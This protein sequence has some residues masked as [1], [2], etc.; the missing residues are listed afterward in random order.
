MTVGLEPIVDSED[1]AVSLDRLRRAFETVYPYF[2][3]WI[4]GV[5][6]DLDSGERLLYAVLEH[7]RRVGYFLVHPL[8]RRVLKANALLILDP[9]RR[10]GIATA[11]YRCLLSDAAERYDFVFTQAKRDHDVAL[12]LLETIGFDR[13]GTLEHLIEE[14]DDNLVFV[15]DLANRSGEHRLTELAAWV[16]DEPG[17]KRFVPAEA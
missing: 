3:E 6:A 9:A 7:D 15:Y 13:I 1:Q 17:K 11:A 14:A 12:R 8:D 4:S 16:Y 5:R 2:A 10:R